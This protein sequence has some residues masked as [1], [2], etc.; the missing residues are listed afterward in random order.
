MG[1]NNLIHAIDTQ[2][3]FQ[4]K[5]AAL[6]VW[7]IPLR[8]QGSCNTALV[9]VIRFLMK[10]WSHWNDSLVLAHMII[11]KNVFIEYI[12]QTIYQF[13]QVYF[14]TLQMSSISWKNT[15][16]HASLCRC[17][18]KQILYKKWCDSY[19]KCC[20]VHVVSVSVITNQ[21]LG[22]LKWGYP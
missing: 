19:T 8:R 13:Q 7:E 4:F 5:H 22:Y 11:R 17:G 2:E 15:H 12:A 18:H 1:N 3:L 6:S 20:C 14:V 9:S 10:S 21:S 16:T